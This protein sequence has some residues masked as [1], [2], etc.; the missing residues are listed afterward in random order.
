[1]L[2]QRQRSVKLWKYVFIT[3]GTLSTTCTKMRHR[4]KI[5][6]MKRDW[7]L[8]FF[9]R[10]FFHLQRHIKTGYLNQ[11]SFIGFCLINYSFTNMKKGLNVT[12]VPTVFMCRYVIVSWLVQLSSTLR[13]EHKGWIMK[14]AKKKGF[15]RID[16]RDVILQEYWKATADLFESALT[17]L[18]SNWKTQYSVIGDHPLNSGQL[19]LD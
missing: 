11:M 12:L 9:L 10:L 19:V 18:M 2:T 15:L 13:K 5:C 14:R 17:F 6:D 8:S 3:H 4:P 1:M 16:T 7:F